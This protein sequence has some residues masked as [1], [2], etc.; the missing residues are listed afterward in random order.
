MSVLTRTTTVEA[1]VKKVF[2]YVLDPR[3]L[4]TVPEVALAQVDIKPDGVGTSAKLWGHFLGFHIEGDL[5]YAEVV[6]P[7]RVVI[8]ISFFMEHPTWT[9]TF[10]PVDGGTKVTMQGEWHVRIPAVGKPY[11]TMLAKEHG[12]F[13]DEILGNIKGALEKGTAAA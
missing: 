8:T 12:P 1:P 4:W 5:K 2:D 13:V 9:L 3:N 11:E 6:R 7:E 10:E